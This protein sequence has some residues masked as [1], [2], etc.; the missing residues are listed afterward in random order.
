MGLSGMEILLP[1]Q[2]AFKCAARLK[3]Q[4]EKNSVCLNP[5][6][7]GRIFKLSFNVFID[8]SSSSFCCTENT[9]A[10]Y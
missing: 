6:L 5:H 9:L 10:L 3:K 1:A 4:G 2:H 7:N 8:L